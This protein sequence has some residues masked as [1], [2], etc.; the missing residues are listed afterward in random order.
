MILVQT[1]KLEIQS[2]LIYKVV[3]TNFEVGNFNFKVG[4]VDLL[5]CRGKY[6]C[7]LV[8]FGQQMLKLESS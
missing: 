5:I 6:F 1:K 8:L 2:N 4:Y 3:K 7:L